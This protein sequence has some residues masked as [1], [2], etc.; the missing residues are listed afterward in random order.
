[1]SGGRGSRRFPPNRGGTVIGYYRKYTV[2]HGIGRGSCRG[3]RPWSCGDRAG[4]LPVLAG[5]V[6]VAV[7]GTVFHMWH[8][9]V[10]WAPQVKVL[11]APAG[12]GHAAVLNP[13]DGVQARAPGSLGDTWRSRALRGRS[14]TPAAGDGHPSSRGPWRHR[15]PSRAGGGPG[16]IHMVRWNPDGRNWRNS[17]GSSAEPVLSRVAG[18]TVLLQH[19]RWRSGDRSQRM[20]P[21][22][23]PLWEWRPD[24]ACPGCRGGVAGL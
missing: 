6:V 20:G 24:A 16:A 19:P 12:V 3:Y 1:M 10:R 7:G 9:G 13:L 5:G 14:G 11:R 23:H 8:G 15:T 22:S 18:P 2:G 21:R 4:V 17:V